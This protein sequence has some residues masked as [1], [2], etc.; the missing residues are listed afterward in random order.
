MVGM[1]KLDDPSRRCE[2]GCEQLASTAAVVKQA[3][4]LA[5]KQLLKFHDL[6]HREGAD[7]WDQ[8][9]GAYC[10]VCA[11]GRCRQSDM[12]WVDRVDWEVT[13]GEAEPGQEGYI[14]IYT[15]HHKTARATAKKALLLPIIISAASVDS[16]PWLPAARQAFE[17]VGLKLCGWI[18]GPMFRPLGLDGE[19]LCKRGMCTSEVSAFIRLV[20]E[21]SPDVSLREEM[22]LA[23]AV[24]A[25]TDKDGGSQS[26]SQRPERGSHPHQRE[27]FP[28]EVRHVW[29]N[30]TH[31]KKKS[32]HSD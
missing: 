9:F 4:A 31:L 2:G 20:L 15:R 5:V 19:C 3:E 13:E 10:L 28:D 1:D 14:V 8:A 29:V 23:E 18:K 22:S 6:L 25:S 17:R 24:K 16:R 27:T 11:Y 26:P 7:A 30:V 12:S 21:V 32:P